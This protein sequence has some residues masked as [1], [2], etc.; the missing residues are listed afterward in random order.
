MS[1][2]SVLK[3]SNIRAQF[4]QHFPVPKTKF[5]VAI[6]APPT[7][8]KYSLIG[9]AFDYLLRLHLKH[10]FPKSVTERWVAEAAVDRMKL[11]SGEYVRIGE[12][13]KPWNRMMEPQEQY[14]N[15][16]RL[17][18]WYPD[19]SQTWADAASSS[20]KTLD[21]AK[22]HCENFIKAGDITD[23]LI[24]SVL[25]LASLDA[26]FRA[27][28]IFGTPQITK[29]DVADIENLLSVMKNSG[30]LRPKTRAF[31]NPTFGEGSSLVGGADADLIIDKMLIDIK[32]TKSISFTQDMYN[33][34]LGYY[35]LSTFKDKLGGI[36]NL[37]IYFSRYGVLHTVPIPV[38]DVAKTIIGWFEEYR[39]SKSA[40]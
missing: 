37:G 6:Q 10:T 19:H 3:D 16:G 1:L 36:A 27:G 32:T 14:P 34:L 31:L 13:I 8:K 2:T 33:Q 40:S 24:K 21:H 39:K 28:K 20:E 30:L 22:K 12:V 35:A 7:T 23:D 38:G 26:V 15:A 18:E 4:K 29:D 17:M 9:T 25:S 5:N 11:V